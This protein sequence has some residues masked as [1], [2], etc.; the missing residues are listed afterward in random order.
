MK[1]ISWGSHTLSQC[2]MAPALRREAWLAWHRA[3]SPIQAWFLFGASPDSPGTAHEPPSPS[4]E[5]SMLL[6][7]LLLIFFPDG[8]GSWEGLPCKG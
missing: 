2:P 6:S 8:H 5:A 4:F 7:E 3:L 1:A